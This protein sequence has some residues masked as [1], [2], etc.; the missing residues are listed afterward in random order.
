MTASH[1]RMLKKYAISANAIVCKSLCGALT[2]EYMP[3]I[4]SIRKVM[5]T[6]ERA[7]HGSWM[8]NILAVLMRRSAM[9]LIIACRYGV[10]NWPKPTR[11]CYIQYTCIIIAN[12]IMISSLIFARPHPLCGLFIDLQHPTIFFFFFKIEQRHFFPWRKCLAK[13]FARR[14]LLCAP[15]F[16]STNNDIKFILNWIKVQFLIFI[17][18]LLLSVN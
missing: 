2:R 16:D 15:E 13:Y 3:A 11:Q 10:A 17:H 5:Q 6:I 18:N 9:Y 4:Y 14:Y 8:Y 7:R 12:K 1:V